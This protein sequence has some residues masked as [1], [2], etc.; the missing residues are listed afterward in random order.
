[1][2]DLGGYVIILVETKE[3]KIKLYGSPADK[4]DL[5]VGDEILEV[6]GKSLDDASHT[7]VISHIHQCIRSR[8]ICLR[9]KRRSGNRL[10]LDLAANS[11]VQDAFVIAVEQQARERL[12]RLSAL[13]RIKPVDMT[14]LSQQLNQT[15]S[16][17]GQQ[18]LNGFI[19]SS[20]IYVTS[21]P[22]YP[23]TNS[24]S[25]AGQPTAASAVAPTTGAAAQGAQIASRTPGGA[26]A[27][28]KSPAHHPD[29]VLTN[30]HGGAAT[31]LLADEA[32]PEE[33]EL[34]Q[35]LSSGDEAEAGGAEE[36]EDEDAS[37]GEGGAGGPGR[38]GSSSVGAALEPPLTR[39]AAEEVDKGSRRRG[40]V[41]SAV[42][43]GVVAASAPDSGRPTGLR[44][45]T[46]SD[47]M[48]ALDHRPD[49]GE[50]R[51]AHR[52]MAVDVPDSFVGRT[53]TP[54]RYPPPRP[55]GAA[56][57]PAGRNLQHHQLHF[58]F[59]GQPSA[60]A[61]VP[62]ANGSRAK[63]TVA[64]AA[65]VAPPVAAPRMAPALPPQE[66]EEEDRVSAG[67][68]RE[69]L[70]S[71]RK[72]QEALRKRKEEEERAAAEREFLR[73]SLRDSRKLHALESRPPG[74][75]TTSSSLRGPP[76]SSGHVN[77]GY[78]S[79]DISE[80]DSEAQ[81][82]LHRVISLNEL[83]SA[84]QRLAAAL[85][86]S[87]SSSLSLRG[88]EGQVAAVQTLLLSQ[89][90]GQALSVHN[91]VQEVWNG[92][93]ASGSG[94]PRG[95]PRPPPG[96]PVCGDTQALA[97]ECVECLQP[98]S[99]PD[100]AELVELLTRYETEGLLQAHDGLALTRCLNE[101][102]APPPMLA[103]MALPPIS[104]P[105][106]NT[107]AASSSVS[108]RSSTHHPHGSESASSASH[109][110]DED[111]KIIKIE[112]TNEPLGATVRNEGE[113]VVI[114]RIVRGGAA[115]K[116]G[117]L[118]EGDEILEVNG[119][120]MRGK[121]VNDVCDLL[122]AMSGTLTFLLVPAQTHPPLQPM[123]TDGRALPRPPP[124]A[125]TTRDTLMH[126]KAHFDYDPEEDAYIPCRE[127]GISFQKGDILHV[128][129]QEDPN[130]WQ[131]FREGEE[132]QTL[133]G[134][135]PSRSFQHQ[136]EAMKQ[137][138]VG[139]KRTK[140]KVK[141]KGGTL[142]LC[143]KKN[144]K[145]KKKKKV[146][147]NATYNDGG[148]QPYTATPNDDY[149]AEEILTY[150]EVALYYPRANHKRPIVL[151]GPPNIGR[152]ELRQRLMEDSDRFAAAIPHTSRPRKDGEVD[153]QDYHFISRAQFEADIISHRFVEH[154]EYERAYYGTS[155]DA[156]RSVVASAKICVLNLHPQ[157]LRILRASDLKPYVVFVAPPS[158]EKLRQKKI[159]SGEA[160]K[161]EELK[162]IIEKA[163][164]MEEKYGHYFDMI[165]VNNDTERAYQQL[166]NEI[167]GLERE[168]QWV[169]ASW[170][171]ST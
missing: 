155:V 106:V 62:A 7:E 72:F 19:E 85:R 82:P 53:K 17:E 48:M 59:R 71:I 131:A 116:S 24:T 123:I 144:A 49:A 66:E 125:P 99:L 133:A 98:C 121:S 29:K 65:R 8:T 135:I 41:V 79:E 120:E 40:G 134:L 61:V 16:T 122:S 51:P 105:S 9:V 77:D 104:T 94:V 167:N 126:V 166:L 64:P 137:S 30:G 38:R 118:R 35:T 13:K 28:V 90:F 73:S 68:T 145:K 154:G 15:P 6:N 103:S 5:E 97:R 141:G 88:L 163:R 21:I 42:S 54:P 37:S 139:D 56:P 169:P 31:A 160:F 55:S 95:Q 146:A 60:P 100:A 110:V 83:A 67:P 171:K 158:L 96:P 101:D 124:P 14:K 78:C 50:E 47:A 25:A 132:D 148:Y 114:G 46:A 58:N 4:A 1:M 127:L 2:V 112:K 84:L 22:E 20:P 107:M 113:A 39:R 149:D 102:A 130:W 36:E 69:Q 75:Q 80:R 92:R 164:E 3:K 45:D 115:D 150:E 151:I 142:L 76:S 74:Q 156:I 87:A 89:E 26:P 119:V 159:R 33:I 63:A 111:I 44:L 86:K 168:P 93:V 108:L 152:H 140:E 18:E 91:R 52:E 43:G 11:N 70:D 162:D 12:E 128:I 32:P 57:T 81:Y 147:Y 161:E 129:S 157:S 143:A 23:V 34:K 27:G 165:I 109:Y 10:A 170:V 153:S 136:R 117:L 138:I